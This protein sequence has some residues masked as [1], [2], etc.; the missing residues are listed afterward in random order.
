MKVLKQSDIKMSSI[1]FPFGAD[2][3]LEGEGMRKKGPAEL[4]RA[5]N[6]IFNIL[7]TFRSPS[8]LKMIEFFVFQVFRKAREAI[9][10]TILFVFTGP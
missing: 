7:E 6:D 8:V 10:D 5:I 9:H 3:L 2:Q 1:S 4:C